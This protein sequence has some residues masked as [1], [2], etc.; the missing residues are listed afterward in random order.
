M[1]LPALVK[2]TSNSTLAEAYADCA[3]PFVAKDRVNLTGML[4]TAAFTPVS[5]AKYTV[6]VFAALD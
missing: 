4:R 1:V 6:T 5:G 3:I 2:N